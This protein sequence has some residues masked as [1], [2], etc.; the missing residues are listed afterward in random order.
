M[1][2][3]PFID[4][5]SAASYARR[6]NTVPR[7]VWGTQDGPEPNDAV[8]GLNAQTVVHGR[9]S[10]CRSIDTSERMRRDAL[11]RRWRQ[12]RHE[13]GRDHHRQQSADI[14]WRCLGRLAGPERDPVR[15]RVQ[16]LDQRLQAHLQGLGRHGERYPRPPEGRAEHPGDDCRREDPG[17]G[18]TEQLERRPRTDSDREPREL[19]HD[20]CGEHE[21][22]SDPD[23]RLLREGDRHNAG[24]APAERDKQL[25]PHCRGRYVPRSGDGGLRVRHPQVHE[26]RDLV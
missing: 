18:R 8:G 13:Q 25:L 19:R 6:S 21:R 17:H 3:R 12:R 4:A 9:C 10:N 24:E 14:W 7:R 1:L 23:L 20:Q 22:V 5:C 11:R 2:A 15:G 16:G 26:D